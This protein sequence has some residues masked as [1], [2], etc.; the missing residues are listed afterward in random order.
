MKRKLTDYFGEV[1]YAGSHTSA[2]LAV[3]EGK[4]DA[5][6][7]AD[8]TLDWSVD[9]GTFDGTTFRIVWTSSLLPL[10]PFAWRADLLSPE[11]QEQIRGAILNLPNTPEGQ[12]FLKKTRSDGV[13]TVDDSAYDGVREVSAQ[14]EEWE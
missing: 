13:V 14:Y 6:A 11:L 2:Q 9:N 4:A 3:L 12:E 5:A 10:D 7:V 1:F 8:V